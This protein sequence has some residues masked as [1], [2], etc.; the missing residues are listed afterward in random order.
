[1]Y[2]KKLF[3]TRWVLFGEP[4]HCFVV[5]WWQII[6]NWNKNKLNIPHN[7]SELQIALTQNFRENPVNYY[8]RNFCKTSSEFPWLNTCIRRRVSAHFTRFGR[9]N[10]FT[11]HSS[12]IRYFDGCYDDVSMTGNLMDV[13]W[14]ALNIFRTKSKIIEFVRTCFA[15]VIITDS[16][17]NSAGEH[18]E[19][20]DQEHN[21]EISRLK[22]TIPHVN[23]I[24]KIVFVT[25]F[26]LSL[27]HN[28]TIHSQRVASTHD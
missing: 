6:V 1:M 20:D 21:N 14:K 15:P 26:C 24:I 19:K 4:S 23:S 7:W 12:F 28:K 22:R 2:I 10:V 3:I 11:I 27:R 17:N 25:Y 16:S 18:Y 9:R 8:S 13:I 5:T